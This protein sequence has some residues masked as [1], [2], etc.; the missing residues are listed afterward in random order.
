M[1]VRLR[2]AIVHTFCCALLLA[3]G[4]LAI[5]PACSPAPTACADAGDCFVGESCQSGACVVDGVAGDMDG[6]DADTTT[7]M[8]GD[9]PANADMDMDVLVPECPAARPD[10]CED[11]CVDLQNDPG[12]CGDCDTACGTGEVCDQGSC[13][14]IGD[15]R[16]EGNNCVGLTY[17]D[18][19][20]G[21]CKP[22]CDSDAQCGDGYVCDMDSNSC[23]CADGFHEC[24]G[25]CSPNDSVLTCGDRCEPCPQ[26]EG[27]TATCEM[28]M[29]CGL[30]CDDGYELCGGTCAVCPDSPGVNATACMGN[31]C[32]VTS[33]IS[34]YTLCDD[35]CCAPPLMT[36]N[37]LT[38]VGAQEETDMAIDSSG[39]LHIAFYDPVESAI[40][41]VYSINNSW[42]APEYPDGVGGIL[43]DEDVG[44]YASIVVDA[45]G[46]PHMLYYNVSR[47][48]LVHLERSNGN[49]S[50][51]EVVDG[52]PMAV[53]LHTSAAFDSAG[54]LHVVYYDRDNENLR[55]AVRATNGTW[56]AGEVIDARPKVGL[57]S[58]L[59][60]DSNDNLHVAY[61]D[62]T[63]NTLRYVKTVNGQWGNSV[64]IDETGNVGWKPSLVVD[65]QDNLHVVYHSYTDNALRYI[66]FQNLAWST[67]TNITSS[68]VAGLSNDLGVDAQGN[69][70]AIYYESSS[71]DLRYIGFDGA[72]WSAPEDL[73]TMGD[74]GQNPS[75]AIDAYGRVHAAY[76][77][78][79]SSQINYTNYAP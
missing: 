9:M 19:S 37:S 7:D 61:R 75:I 63:N 5:T 16:Q 64:A 56:T 1:I 57:S 45:Q 2:S 18:M 3:L 35:G 67:P 11:L 6:A 21:V 31:A 58:S 42:S 39:V 25:A 22:G 46:K 41:Y 49:W 71:R 48:Q 10:S 78:N 38:G 14:E 43:T 52:N 73:V 15:C 34:P 55:Y 44:R 32:V 4:M 47:G 77:N 65:P 70:H 59:A 30:E 50:M 23:A 79:S 76:L 13:L 27:S 72:Q 36:R 24:M 12:Y 60:I 28:A 62:Q 53:G 74:V 51:P 40:G 17:C 26:P 66:S 29:T 20:D 68:G 8:D 33:C 54:K 69:L